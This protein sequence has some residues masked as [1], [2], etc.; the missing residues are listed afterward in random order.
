MSL[1]AAAKVFDILPGW[2]WAGLFVGAVLHGC[3]I[4]RERD[5]VKLDAAG[6]RTALAQ[7]RQWHSDE[8]AAA[9]SEVRV[10]EDDLR[11]ARDAQERKDADAQETIAG[12]REDLRRRA[13]AAGGPGLRDPYAPACPAGEPADPAG[14]TAVAGGADPAGAG[15]SLSAELEG[16]LIERF[17]RA[18]TINIAYA[19][20]RADSI[21][22]REKLREAQQRLQDLQLSPPSPAPQVPSP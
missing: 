10:L 12:L 19:S 7:E 9:H 8:L 14:A 22:L 16:F 4:E 15:R 5:A 21:G 3:S 1:V 17:T 20:C 11:E 6:A 2:V 13:R 18:D